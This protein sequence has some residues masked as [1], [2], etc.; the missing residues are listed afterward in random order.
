M[1]MDSPDHLL[2]VSAGSC[3]GPSRPACPRQV[4]LSL[5]QTWS[6]DLHPAS[7]RNLRGP[8]NF[9]FSSQ[10]LLH[11][12]VQGRNT[13]SSHPLASGSAVLPLHV[14][15][16]VAPRSALCLF[17][18]PDSASPTRSWAL[19]KVMEYGIPAGLDLALGLDGFLCPADPILVSWGRSCAAESLHAGSRWGRGASGDSL[20]RAAGPAGRVGLGV[21]GGGGSGGGRGGAS[22]RS[23]AEGLRRVCARTWN[24]CEVRAGRRAGLAV[25]MPWGTGCSPQTLGPRCRVSGT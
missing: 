2:L 12:Q 3:S 18:A 22:V 14:C 23:A 25:E 20:S 17:S 1:F 11:H 10:G 9:P 7:G 6:S 16:N 19:K 8:L 13:G 4:F 24:G 5:S 15:A 21:D